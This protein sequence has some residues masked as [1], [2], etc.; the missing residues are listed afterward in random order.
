MR[1]AQAREYVALGLPCR[2]KAGEIAVRER[3]DRDIAG[4]LREINRLHHCVEIG[5]T[6]REQMHRSPQPSSGAK[7]IRYRATIKALKPDDHEPT[8]PRLA[9]G[10]WS[11]ELMGHP[12]ADRL[13]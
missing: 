13:H 6:G 4:R 9:G 1:Q 11:V 12:R 3:Q 2:S 5:R 8:L 7:R 10:P